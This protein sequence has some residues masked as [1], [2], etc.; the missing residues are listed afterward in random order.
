MGSN[1]NYMM[2]VTH[3]FIILLSITLTAGNV[4]TDSAIF[5]RLSH[6]KNDG[7]VNH[8]NSV[9]EAMIADGSCR[10]IR[11]ELDGYALWQDPDRTGEVIEA[12]KDVLPPT[13][14]PSHFVLSAHQVLDELCPVAGSETKEEFSCRGG[15]HELSVMAGAMHNWHRALCARDTDPEWEGEFDPAYQ[16]QQVALTAGFMCI[17]A[18]DCNMSS[19]PAASL[20]YFAESAQTTN[21]LHDLLCTIVPWEAVDFAEGS[22]GVDHLA[23]LSAPLMEMCGCAA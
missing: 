2:Q 15:G 13:G 12:L 10:M 1:S 4:F 7:V 3:A 21:V 22:D 19:L 23:E 16:P 17:I 8:L 5:E 20:A 14:K 18:C 9:D 11:S 6:F